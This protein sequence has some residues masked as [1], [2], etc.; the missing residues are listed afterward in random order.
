MLL[1]LQ[2]GLYNLWYDLEVKKVLAKKAEKA[3]E[4]GEKLPYIDPYKGLTLSQLQGPFWLYLS[5]CLVS[6]LVFCAETV[7]RRLRRNSTM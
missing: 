5:G 7:E 2:A 4:T 1:L 6:T 3:K